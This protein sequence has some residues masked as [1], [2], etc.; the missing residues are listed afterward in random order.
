MGT[1]FMQSVS[2]CNLPCRYHQLTKESTLYAVRGIAKTRG[3]HCIMD[4]AGPCNVQSANVTLQPV[5]LYFATREG[6]IS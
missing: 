3:S 2:L 5:T 1:E 6:S 4:P